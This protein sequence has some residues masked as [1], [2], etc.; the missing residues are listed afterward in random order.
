MELVWTRSLEWI[1]ATLER[2]G[3]EIV[4]GWLALGS[5]RWALGGLAAALVALWIVVGIR[6]A[7]RLRHGRPPE[8]LL[9]RGTLRF[10]DAPR[11]P[12]TGDRA[13]RFALRAALAN[14]GERPVSV[15][16][17]AIHTEYAPDPVVIER[18]DAL[19]PHASVELMAEVVGPAGDHGSLEVYV[20][21]PPRRPGGRPGLWRLRSVLTW[22][23]WNARYRVEPLEQRVLP[24]RSLPSSRQ[25]VQDRGS[26]R[27][28]QQALRAAAERGD[29]EAGPSA[30]SARGAPAPDPVP[31]A[32]ADDP[33]PKERRGAIRSNPDRD[34]GDDGA[35]DRHH[36]ERGIRDGEALDRDTVDPATAPS[37]TNDDPRV[38]S[39]AADPVPA[40]PV[41]AAPVHADPVPADPSPTD[42]VPASVTPARDAHVPEPDEDE[43][44]RDPP[45]AEPPAVHEE[46]EP[47]GEDDVALGAEDLPPPVA[48]LLA[49]LRGSDAADEPG[50]DSGRADV[51]AIEDGDA[52][53]R[54]TYYLRERID[55]DRLPGSA[56]ARTSQGE[57][58]TGSGGGD[59]RSRGDEAP[60]DGA[61]RR[62]PRPRLEFPDD[63]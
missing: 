59:E 6:R 14:L 61:P 4:D 42:P 5:L 17:I 26:W 8:L 13:D 35:A 20:S 28:Q 37:S 30:P 36:P 22:E 19:A 43:E 51:D 24:A 40:D 39:V 60:M 27:R 16:E 62:E 46:L 53:E 50:A 31:A 48:A 47:L 11:D 55:L 38:A 34:A 54:D 56:S 2:W 41:P 52:G 49:D 10:I 7:V 12:A 18:V 9:T 15:V 23:A 58:A 32:P 57:P 21:T 25:A 33:E 1:G 63:F 3:P 29:A 44:P 45:R